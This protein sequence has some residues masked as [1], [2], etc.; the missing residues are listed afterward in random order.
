MSILTVGFGTSVAMWL[1][2]YISHIPPVIVPAPVVAVLMLACL[3]LGGMT[4]GRHTQLGSMG[5]VLVGLV[6]SIV[7]MLILGSLLMDPESNRLVPSALLWLPGSLVGGAV[8]GGIGGAIGAR[9]PRRVVDADHWRS[10]FAAIACL[11]TLLVVIAG[12]LVTSWEEGLAVPD[13]PNTFGTNMFLYPLARMTG[14]IYYEHAHRLYGALVGFTT[15]VL[16]IVLWRDNDGRPWLRRL[17]V[18]AVIMVIAQGVMGGLRV[19]SSLS[20]STDFNATAPNLTLA[21]VH[22][23]F[24][25]CFFVLMTLIWA[26]TTRTWRSAGEAQPNSSAGT[27]YTLT[28]A[29]AAALLVQLALGALYRHTYSVSEPIPFAGVAHLTL[30]AIVAA[31]AFLTGLRG[32]ALY[33]DLP[34]LRRLGQIL[35]ALLAVQFL[36]GLAA[37]VAVFVRRE[38]PYPIEVV[39]TTAHQANGAVLFAV[40]AQLAVWTRRLLVPQPE[41]VLA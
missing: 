20:G 17:G 33:G 10:G 11:A 23:V 29:L 18:A 15:I 40:A 26:F 4:V 1:I 9:L 2:G 12:G 14:G 39:L 38:G 30:A 25:Q 21:I 27:D 34:V 22:G 5:G 32:W 24:G 8:L 36:L 19:D 16:A 3:V 37:L 41:P 28:A 6:A 13:W 35:I 31:M 7:N